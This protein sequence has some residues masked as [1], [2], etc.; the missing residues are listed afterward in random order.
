MLE[1]RPYLKRVYEDEI[2]DCMICHDIA[3]RVS[4]S[5]HMVFGR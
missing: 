1:L 5:T 2:V 4:A 3:V